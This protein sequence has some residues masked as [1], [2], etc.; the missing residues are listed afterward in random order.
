MC[1]HVPLFFPSAPSAV[2]LHLQ[3]SLAL[4][5][6]APAAVAKKTWSRSEAK[7]SKGG[8]RG[9]QKEASR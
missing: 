8:R 5:G 2:V 3:A 4:H 1:L 7:S 9:G 6:V